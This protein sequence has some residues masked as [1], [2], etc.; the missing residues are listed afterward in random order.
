MN[1]FSTT[2]KEKRIN[3]T[4]KIRARFSHGVFTPLE[5]IDIPDGKELTIDISDESKKKVFS[6]V[7]RE[8]AGAWKNSID[9]KELLKNIYADR[10]ISTRPEVKL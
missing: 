3:M 6:D 4:K 8:T 7:L 2:I 5:R 1:I 10:H 9:C